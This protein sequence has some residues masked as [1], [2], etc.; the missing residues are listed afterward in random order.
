MKV[1]KLCE[2]D[3]RLGTTRIDRVCFVVLRGASN[4]GLLLN[5]WQ[6]R[7]YAGA[8]LVLRLRHVNDAGLRA[9]LANEG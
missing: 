8:M 7:L 5:S 1:Y 6:Q 2:C 3:T 4:Y 9:R